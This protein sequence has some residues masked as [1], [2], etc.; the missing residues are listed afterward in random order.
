MKK[1]GLLSAFRLGFLIC[2]AL[3]AVWQTLAVLFSYQ[4]NDHYFKSGDFLSIAAVVFAI[5]GAAYGIIGVLADKKKKLGSYQSIGLLIAFIVPF[6]TN[7]CVH[8]QI[9]SVFKPIFLNKKY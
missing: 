4:P 3:T 2:S 1:F 5:M 6:A 8:M 9:N 7:F